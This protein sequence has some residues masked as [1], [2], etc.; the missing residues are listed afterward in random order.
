M[1]PRYLPLIYPYKIVVMSDASNTCV[2]AA[3]WLVWEEPNSK[4]KINYESRLI[5]CR[6]KVRALKD[7]NSIAKA[8]LD[9]VI[10]AREIILCIKNAFK[11]NFNVFHLFTDSMCVFHW[12]K[13]D[14]SRLGV[15]QK[16]RVEKI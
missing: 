9:G 11:C 5:M 14:S 13:M 7:K 8:E 10:L 12:M 16:N 6:G 1:G 4:K 2:A 15:Y 3:A